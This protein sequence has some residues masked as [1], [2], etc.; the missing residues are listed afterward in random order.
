MG[1]TPRRGLN[2]RRRLRSVIPIGDVSRGRNITLQCAHAS[3]RSDA[4]RKGRYPEI[5]E[6]RKLRNHAV[7]GG[8]VIAHSAAHD[9]VLSG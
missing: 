5:L 7:P 6:E 2:S 3:E 9:N 4:Y 1:R 8:G